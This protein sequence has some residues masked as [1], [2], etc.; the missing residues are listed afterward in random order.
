[1][2]VFYI[3]FHEEKAEQQSLW[4]IKQRYVSFIIIIINN[5]RSYD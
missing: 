3:V 2:S 4:N 5:N 1:M